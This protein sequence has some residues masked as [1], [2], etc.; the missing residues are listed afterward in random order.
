MYRAR[1]VFNAPVDREHPFYG[2]AKRTLQEVEQMLDDMRPVLVHAV[3]VTIQRTTD[4]EGNKGWDTL[5]TLG[6]LGGTP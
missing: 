2:V 3:S 5:S 4:P 6:L 1:V